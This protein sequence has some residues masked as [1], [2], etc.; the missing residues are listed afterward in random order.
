MDSQ[1]AT[2]Y[3]FLT[4]YD[5]PL[6]GSFDVFFNAFIGDVAGY[7][8][9]FIPH[10]L[11]YWRR[12]SEDNI[13]FLT[14]EE[15][16]RDLPAVIRKTAAF[17]GK[18]ISDSGVAQLADHLSFKRM[19]TNKAVNKEDYEE[20]S[21]YVRLKIKLVRPVTFRQMNGV[22]AG[23]FMRKGE[24]GDW[25]NHLSPEQVERISEWERKYLAGTDL[26]FVYDL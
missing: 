19:K 15:M 17:L 5:R 10:V 22:S 23:K 1:V 26:T 21:K 25:R 9:P 20:L 8:C 13:L 14:F 6:T 12:R 4:Q 11:K 18:N 3:L 7:Y 24:T 16:K 2:I